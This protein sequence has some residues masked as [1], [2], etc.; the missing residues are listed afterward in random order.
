MSNNTVT[1]V[2]RA[3]LKIARENIGY[4]TQM[5]T[6]KICG[7]KQSDLVARW[8]S[9]EK[10][11]TWKQLEKASNKYGVNF[12]LLTSE[13]EIS[14]NK[15]IPDFRRKREDG[16]DLVNIKEY[17]N[18]LIQ[19]QK[20]LSRIVKNEYS[21]EN[22]LV[23]SGVSIENPKELANFI[24]NTI[25]YDFKSVK[26][27]SSQEE[28]LRYFRELVEE[29][30]IFVMKTL[31]SKVIDRQDMQGVYISDL[32]A[33]L[34]A[35][36]RRDTRTAQMFT[37]AHEL[38][39]L[40]KDEE[41]VTNIAGIDFRD[42]IAKDYIEVFCN[43]VASYLVLP[44]ESIKRDNYTVESINNIAEDCG[45][46]PIA[47]FYRLKNANLINQEDI[48]VFERQILEEMYKNL[49]RKEKTDQ[50]KNSGGDYNNNMKD[51][52]GGLFNKF[53]FSM[54]TEN[55]LS[56]VEAQNLLKF[57]VDKL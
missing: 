45:V 35:L 30:G 1:F 57:S 23:G 33:P 14:R 37:L 12:F 22:K 28:K 27:I 43:K 15:E 50:E 19:R 31:T 47:V 52:N 21:K 9:G 29:Q 17:I 54:Y 38:A 10:S 13:K 24:R 7:K 41:G 40:F 44:D 51:T 16:K 25:N 5:A 18:F 39:H 2:N 42:S 3:N 49:K 6:E 32:Y 26:K 20:F 34:I 55:K 48:D 56:P 36:N 11:P 4:T 53:I 8:E 46:S